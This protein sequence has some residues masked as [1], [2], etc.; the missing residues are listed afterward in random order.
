MKVSS[1]IRKF[2]VLLALS[3]LSLTMMNCSKKDGDTATPQAQ[4]VGSW[5][6]TAF[7]VKEGSKP[8]ADQFPFLVAILPCFKDI[9]LTFNSN[10]TVSGS[11]P[12]ACQSDV[13][14]VV[15]DIT[16]S[17]YEV[18]GDQLI[19]TDSNGTQSAIA[20]SFSGN[21]MSWT[22]SETTSGITTTTRIVLT[23]Q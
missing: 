23:K 22:E 15:G 6:F 9:V 11:I 20:V 13:D 21:T 14:D 5:K 12:A 19:L 3:S 1:V 8:E 4:I 17:K 18:K 2:T 16:K 10:G 7:F